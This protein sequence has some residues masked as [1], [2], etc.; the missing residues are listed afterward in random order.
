M[1]PSLD[2]W[3]WVQAMLS[4]AMIGM[5][6]TNVRQICLAYE[7]GW[8]IEAVLERPCAQDVDDI[9]DIADDTVIEFENIKER[10]SLAAYANVT[11]LTICSTELLEN[12]VS[13]D[14]RIVYRRK[15]V[16]PRN[17]SSAVGS[18]T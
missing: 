15:E 6:S 16:A 10:I 5:V 14:R 3:V 8:M 17:H 1:K 18:G 11:A 9:Q 2:D 7:N 12:P 13:A 4:Q